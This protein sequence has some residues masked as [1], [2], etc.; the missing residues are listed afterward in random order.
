[1]ALVGELV[2]VSYVENLCTRIEVFDL[3][4]HCHAPVPSP[5]HGTIRLLGRPANTA[6]LFYNFSSFSEPPTMY[7]HN[8]AR[9]EHGVWWKYPV[10]ADGASV[11]VKQISYTSK[12]GTQVP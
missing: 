12:D 9:G 5:S 4:G 7:F 3:N 1:F 8:P 2:C 11:E 10:K 6:M